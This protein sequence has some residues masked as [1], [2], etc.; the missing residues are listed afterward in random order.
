MIYTA[1]YTLES[2]WDALKLVNRELLLICNRS[3]RWAAECA[4]AT[5]LTLNYFISNGY[6]SSVRNQDTSL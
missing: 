5:T 3:L 6:D 2:H 1:L 4:F